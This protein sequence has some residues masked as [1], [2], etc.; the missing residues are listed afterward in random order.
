VY[1]Q[2]ISINGDLP[3]S[4]PVDSFDDYPRRNDSQSFGLRKTYSI[5]IFDPKYDHSKP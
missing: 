2:P 1:I 3:T 4:V 5:G